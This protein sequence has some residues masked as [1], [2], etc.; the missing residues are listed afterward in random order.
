MKYY[1]YL[2]IRLVL[3]FFDSTVSKKCNTNLIGQCE[4]PHTWLL[5]ERCGDAAIHFS[6]LGGAEG[7]A[8]FRTTMQIAASCNSALLLAEQ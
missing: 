5:Q 1:T 2:P 6:S 8:L 4:A 7:G 3:H